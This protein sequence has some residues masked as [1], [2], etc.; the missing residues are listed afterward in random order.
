MISS[1]FFFLFDYSVKQL[2]A[3]LRTSSIDLLSLNM[4]R[5]KK[6][7]LHLAS[8]APLGGMAKRLKSIMEPEEDFS[9]E[10]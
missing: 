2:H 9:D 10:V 7:N 8:I 6:R 4:P 5:L 3:L 1:L